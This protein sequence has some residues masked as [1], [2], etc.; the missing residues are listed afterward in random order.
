MHQNN[1]ARVAYPHGAADKV[2]R[3]LVRRIKMYAESTSQYDSIMP[4]L[5][6]SLSR[7]SYS[8]SMCEI[9]LCL[10]HAE[11]NGSREERIRIREW[12]REIRGMLAG[13]TIMSVL[14]GA[15]S[16]PSSTTLPKKC[17][18]QKSAK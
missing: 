8:S 9:F 12:I 10:I 18:S 7:V 5:A 17:K 14:M 2:A 15:Q 11:H 4:S 1:M 16:E 6:A 13:C 3:S